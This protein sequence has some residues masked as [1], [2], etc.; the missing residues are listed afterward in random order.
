MPLRLLSPHR[1]THEEADGEGQRGCFL[2]FIVRDGDE[3]S[4]GLHRL[5]AG[6]AG[7]AFGVRCGSPVELYEKSNRTIGPNLVRLLRGDNHP[8]TGRQYPISGW[9]RVGRQNTEP[10]PALQHPDQGPNTGLRAVLT[11][12]ACRDGILPEYRRAAISDQTGRQGGR[13]V[14]DCGPTLGASCKAPG[15]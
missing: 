2:A 5:V 7:S 12:E 3:D 15:R 4:R 6:S 1:R 9:F 13:P 11:Q 14:H 8:V 10:Q